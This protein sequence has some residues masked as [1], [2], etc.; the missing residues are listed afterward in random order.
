MNTRAAVASLVAIL[1]AGCGSVPAPPPAVSV[2]PVTVAPQEAHDVTAAPPA[3]AEQCDREASLPPGP[4]PPAGAMPPGSTMAAIARRGRLVVGVDQNT[5]QIGFRDP[6]TGRIEG[7]DIDVAREIARAIFDDPD[8]IDL[9]VVDARDRETALMSGQVDVVVRTYS[10]T[11]ERKR[12]VDF[13][14]VYFVAHQRILVP[15]GARI[16]TA[17]DLS[18]KRVCAATGTTSLANLLAMNPRTVV[19]GVTAWTDCLVMLQQNQIDA[20]STD[21][22]VLAGLADQDPTVGHQ[23][24]QGR[25]AFPPRDHRHHVH[26]P[27][28]SGED[29]RRGRP[30]R[31]LR[32]PD[33]RQRG[34]HRFRGRHHRLQ[35]PKIR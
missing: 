7:F 26:L 34:H 9:R 28:R 17:D 27:P 35:E 20:I 12:S 33:Q 30:R 10:I 15:R 14:T 18:G 32:H 25:Q 3:A 11:C 16:D 1:T 23:Q 24:A 2:A 4:L 21:D 22:A 31:R 13:S 19:I 8:R 5:Y 29:N 6:A